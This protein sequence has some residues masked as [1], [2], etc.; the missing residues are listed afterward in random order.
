MKGSALRISQYDD[1][2][3][4]QSQTYMYSDI[5]VLV[6]TLLEGIH[7]VHVTFDS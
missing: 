1:I 6:Q 3:L 7:K 4:V 2:R 5:H